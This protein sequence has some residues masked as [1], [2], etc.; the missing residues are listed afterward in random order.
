MLRL[1][2]PG[3]WI[4]VLL[5]ATSTAAI[6]MLPEAP[7]DGLQYWTFV[8]EHAAV[9]EAAAAKWNPAHP[10]LPVRVSTLTGNTLQTRMLSGFYSGT[11]I[12]DLIEIE[13][14]LIGQVFAGPGTD[15]GLVDLTDMLEREHLL[16]NINAPSL[17]PWTFHGR[18]YGLPHDVHPVML[19]YRAD[20]VEAAGI[21]V[22]RIET[23]DDYFRTMRP[24][25]RDYDG[26]GRVD[27]FLLNLAP[28]SLGLHEVLL[29]QA[30]GGLIAPDGSPTL[31]SEINIRTLA[32]MAV[33]CA[34]PNRVTA[35]VT[36][37]GPS[38]MR[39]ANEGYVLAFIAPDWMAG[40]IRGSL[41][42]MAGKFKVMPLPAWTPGGRHTSV[43][44]G[45]MVGLTKAS[46]NRDA[47]WEFAKKV[48]F[49][50]ETAERI[51]DAFCIVSPIK[52]NWSLPCYDRPD[53]Y[54][55]GQPIGRL[56]LKL[57]TDVPLRVPSPYYSQA[58]DALN[59]AMVAICRQV[60]AQRLTEAAAVL[61][62]ARRELGESQ[63]Q[64]LRLMS[65]N[66]FLHPRTP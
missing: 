61:P 24:L 8:R 15:I 58:G 13:R 20:L 46:P 33:W 44:G 48:Y 50:P 32:Q 27:T 35:E 63:R 65:N 29:L 18:I 9:A 43:L 49:A 7:H 36:V 19:V 47:A 12:G 55:S 38:A 42:N 66:V 11:P 39:L 40:S 45:T 17:S 3:V 10:N 31:N 28:T 6:W 51:F 62:I 56:Y 2:S 60:D 54:F 52:S 21:D 16:E 26:D 41:P 22:S 4:V 34:G 25:M 57:A 30:G 14:G 23:W 37:A 64:I 59:V 53:P 1:F 5:A